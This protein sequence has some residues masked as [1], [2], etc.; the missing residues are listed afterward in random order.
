MNFNFEHNAC[1]IEVHTMTFLNHLRKYFRFYGQYL[2][3][4][5]FRQAL[6]WL[7]VTGAKYIDHEVIVFAHYHNEHVVQI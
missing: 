5:Q 4:G 3:L 6:A 1:V 2:I 7:L